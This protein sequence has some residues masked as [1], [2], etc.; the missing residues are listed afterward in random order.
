LAGILDYRMNRRSLLGAAAGMGIGA[1]LLKGT[2]DDSC[3]AAFAEDTAA[4]PITHNMW[5]WRFD[6][7]GDHKE[8]LERVKNSGM[9]VLLKCFEGPDW[10][11]RHDSSPTSVRGPA[12]VRWFAEFFESNGVP[13]HAWGVVKGQDPAGEAQVASEVLNSGARSM[14]FDLEPP[15]N[16]HYWHGTPES[17]LQFGYEMRSRQPMAQL[18]VAPDARPWQ[19]DAVPTAEFATFVNAIM[20]QSYWQTFNSPTNRRYMSE[21]GYQ[22]GEE[23]MTPELILQATA[24]KL[25]PFGLP[26]RPIGQGTAGG[27]DWQ[28]FVNHAY[29]LGMD[30]VSVWRYGTTNHEVWPTL[31]AMAPAQPAPAAPPVAAPQVTAPAPETPQSAP[32]AIAP[33]ANTAP[34][35]SEGASPPPQAAAQSKSDFGFNT[36]TATSQSASV[37]ESDACATR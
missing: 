23:G 30:S 25:A 2:G 11:S 31:Q 9:G 19:I 6:V 35:S 36:T 32:E 29:S 26:I 18:A 13:F 37:K 34:S 20:P 16:Q 24:D 3:A 8:V 22:I 4:F 5:V 17:A 7:D 14:T 1:V 15:E 27:A 33:P 21:R 10:M 12:Q 28:R